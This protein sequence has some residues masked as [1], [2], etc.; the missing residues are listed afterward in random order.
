MAIQKDILV[1]GI[2]ISAY[3][4][5]S[6]IFIDNDSKKATA[7]VCA[8]GQKGEREIL[9]LSLQSTFTFDYDEDS[10]DSD[11]ISKCYDIIKVHDDYL[12]SIDV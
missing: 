8:Y 12:G 11:P 2:N 6:N 10:G 9:P 7:T 5:I 3:I 1:S 4:K